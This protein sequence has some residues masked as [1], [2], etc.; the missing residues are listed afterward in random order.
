[1][2]KGFQLAFFI[3]QD[4]SAAI[5]V[6]MNA[7]NK[8]SVQ[9]NREQKRAYW[10]DKHLKRKITRITRQ[11]SDALQWLIYF[12]SEGYEKQQEQSEEQTVRVMIIRYIKHL[13]QISTPMSAFYVS[14]GLHRLLYN[15]DRP[16]VQ[17]MYEWMTEHYPG[18]QEYRRVKGA[19]MIQLQERF[20]DAIQ[21]IRTTHGELRFETLE[22]QESW[23]DVIDECLR[24]FR[25]WSTSHASEGLNDANVIAEA[26]FDL[27]V[28]KMQAE[29]D[30]DKIETYH[31]HAFIDPYC[32]Q[33]ITRKLGLDPPRQRLAVPR[34]FLSANMQDH[35]NL[36]GGTPPAPKLTD[37]ERE[38]ISEHLAVQ[39]SRRQRFSPALVKVMAHGKEYVR[40]HPDQTEWRYCELLEGVKLIE[41][42]AEQKGG[43]LLLA[44]HWVDYTEWR[45]IAGTTVVIDLGNRKELLL[46][47]TPTTEDTG[48]ASLA[49]QCRSVVF[50]SLLEKAFGPF[51]WLQ[52]NP[53]LAF[54]AV[55]LLAV[56]WVLG[57]FLARRELAKRQVTVE[58]VSKE[59]AHEKTLR[60]ALQR[61][62]T[63]RSTST[64]IFRL[65][66]DDIHVRST[67]NIERA[68]VHLSANSPLA[69]LEL[70][71][72][73]QNKTSYRT[74]LRSFLGKKEILK[75]TFPQPTRKD[76]SS[77]IKFALPSTLV[78]DGEHYVISLD[79]ISASGKI[80]TYR[81][82]TFLVMKN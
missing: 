44:T 47:I 54:A 25:P 5:R 26:P 43:D 8:R 42:W 76:G 37:N 75:E 22:N 16:E 7:L 18:A 29:I 36:G 71:A 70:P 27:F 69:I 11:N 28:R 38:S 50:F 52:K 41:I 57:A 68:V 33:Q 80:E 66:P 64:E 77:T 46:Q 61:N 4:R 58:A 81:T 17:R 1:M 30:P 9:H 78:E 67:E 51:I 6:V 20:A 14:V 10:R 2:E 56:G 34:F 53:K 12:E 32:H 39:A 24:V 59:L 60:E 48:G 31:C 65:T 19:L 3:L 35:E 23:A 63:N 13:L 49:L 79:S 73:A 21:I 74:V 82:F 72:A 40:L 45:G 62:I 15:Y 55:S